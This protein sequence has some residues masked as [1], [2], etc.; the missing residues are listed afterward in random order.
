MYPIPQ[1]VK[2]LLEGPCLPRTGFLS[3]SINDSLCQ[4]WN[5]IFDGVY[6][7]MSW[8]LLENLMMRIE[9]PEKNI[10]FYMGYSGWGAGQLSGRDGPGSVG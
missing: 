8:E 3:L 5:A 1:P 9:D 4:N 6:M 10:R 2:F 7:G